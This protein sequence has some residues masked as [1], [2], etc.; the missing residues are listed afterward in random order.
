MHCEKV[1]IVLRRKW[2]FDRNNLNKDKLACNLSSQLYHIIFNF[3]LR[4]WPG[5]CCREGI[6]LEK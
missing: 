5:K 1:W 2:N 6:L 3:I 4:Q